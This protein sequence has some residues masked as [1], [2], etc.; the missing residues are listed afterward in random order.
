MDARDKPAHD[1]EFLASPLDRSLPGLARKS[2]VTCDSKNQYC[3]QYGASSR[4][5][6]SSPRMTSEFLASPLNR[7]LPGLTRQSMVTCDSKN[8]YCRQYGA[9]SWMRG[10]SPR[11][12]RSFW[13]H[14]S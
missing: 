8:Q 3:R 2:M 10:S 5:R 7:S 4:M 1:S 11:M 9:S 12:T 14:L 13:H 6:G